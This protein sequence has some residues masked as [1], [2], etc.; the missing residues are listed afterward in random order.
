MS[1][2]SNTPMPKS[3]NTPTPKSSNT[4]KE[5]D[6]TK[7]IPIIIPRNTNDTH[8]NIHHNED[9]QE[10]NETPL[11]HIIIPPVEESLTR[12]K[13]KRF[14]FQTPKKTVGSLKVILKLV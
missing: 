9:E 14:S 6:L 11:S 12:I 8:D 13:M 2:S 7:E 5:K 3:S 1:K 4:S 10:C